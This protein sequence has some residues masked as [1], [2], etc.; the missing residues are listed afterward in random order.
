MIH[1]WKKHDIYL[2]SQFYF[3]LKW[4][5]DLTKSRIKNKKI[6]NLL[7]EFQE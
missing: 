3:R 4:D 5:I 1:L 7:L 6:I 2:V